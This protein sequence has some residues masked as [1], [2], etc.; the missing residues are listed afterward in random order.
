M[1]DGW[2]RLDGGKRGKADRLAWERRLSGRCVTCGGR[3]AAGEH[4]TCEPCDVTKS[5]FGRFVGQT[6]ERLRRWNADRL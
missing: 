3:L 5:A 1:D 6:H 4:V 2:Y